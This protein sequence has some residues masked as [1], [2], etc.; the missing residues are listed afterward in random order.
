MLNLLKK[1]QSGIA[2]ILVVLLLVAGVGLGTYL[3]SQRTNLLPKAEECNPGI[4]NDCSSEE[5]TPEEQA[6]QQKE[7]QQNLERGAQEAGKPLEEYRVDDCKAN[8]GKQGCKEILERASSSQGRQGTGTQGQNTPGDSTATPECE[9]FT[10]CGGNG[11]K[12]RKIS[13]YNDT[14][15]T[16]SKPIELA[17]DEPCGKK[18]QRDASGNIKRGSEGEILYT[19]EDFKPGE[20]IAGLREDNTLANRA[21]IEAQ[22]TQ[23]AQDK[24]ALDEARA[25]LDPNGGILNAQ[26]SEDRLKACNSVAIEKASD[27]SPVQQS[28]CDRIYETVKSIA[29]AQKRFDEQSLRYQECQSTDQTC[30]VLNDASHKLAIQAYRSAMFEGISNG[31]IAGACVKADMGDADNLREGRPATGGGGSSRIFLCRQSGTSGQRPNAQGRY[32]LVW[33]VRNAS[34]QLVEVNSE[35]KQKYG[36]KDGIYT[37]DE[38]PQDI[39]AGHTNVRCASLNQCQLPSPTPTPKPTPSP[40]P[41]TPGLPTTNT[42]QEPTWKNV[43]GR[44]ICDYIKNCPVNHRKQIEG[45]YIDCVKPFRPGDKGVCKQASQP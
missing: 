39:R 1:S 19:E 25:K 4:D 15:K 30:Q 14:E 37:I 27:S 31:T 6:A 23:R 32:P 35:D 40:T 12:V 38:I 44:Y 5:T 29:E 22:N 34:G 13:V 3:V 36:M 2:Q 41:S 8:P 17:S 21:R 16:C 9:N 7:E 18:P 42:P 24:Q 26:N 43:E 10:Y 11:T 28:E 33:R 45:R 20:V